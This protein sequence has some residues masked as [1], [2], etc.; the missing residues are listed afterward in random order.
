MLYTFIPNTIVAKISLLCLLKIF[1]KIPL[2]GQSI[3]FSLHDGSKLTDEGSAFDN[4]NSIASLT[5]D[6]ITL[7]LEALIDENSANAVLNGGAEGFGVNSNGLSD[8][9]Q[10]IDNINGTE[11][12]IF[13]SA[14]MV[15]SMLSIYAIL[16][17]LQMKL[18]YL[19][20]EA[21]NSVSMQTQHLVEKMI[22]QSMKHLRLGKKFHSI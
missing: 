17:N 16:R 5:K 14:L 1:L 7:S 10:R 3:Q 8:Y 18:F 21:N 4:E 2:V 22:F 19:L 12:I 13:L 9:T 15:F 6:G 20:K 11:S